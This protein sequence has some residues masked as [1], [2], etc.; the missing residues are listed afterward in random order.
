MTRLFL[1]RHGEVQTEGIFYGQLDVPLSQTGKQQLEQAGQ[2]LADQELAAVHC[3][4]LQRAVQGATAVGAHHGLEPMA[5]AAFREMNLGLLEGVPHAEARQRLPEMATRR[6]QDMWQYRFPEGGENLQ[7]IADRVNPA[8]DRLLAR[9]PDE[10]VVLVAH[11]ST[12]RVILGQALGLPLRQVFDFSQDFGCIN[13]IDYRI[14][15]SLRQGARVKLLNW[16]PSALR[17]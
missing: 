2:A 10:T 9:Y 5:D 13:R 12:N 15:D 14:R 1:I 16:T 7:D 8:L 4:D 3:S 11:N 6:Y 17:V